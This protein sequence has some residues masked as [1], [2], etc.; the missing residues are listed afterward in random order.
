MIARKLVWALAKLDKKSLL[1]FEEFVASPYFNVNVDLRRF[2]AILLHS[3]LKK[4]KD[5]WASDEDIWQGLYPDTPLDKRRLN[6]LYF[7]LGKLLDD[8]L[9]QREFDEMQ[10][11]QKKVLLDGLL[12]F[13]LFK[14]H[15]E[16]K[17][18]FHNQLIENKDYSSQYAVFQYHLEKSNIKSPFRN[19]I[20]NWLNSYYILEKLQTY[21]SLLSWK[22]MYKLDV[23]IFFMEYIFEKIQTVN[24]IQFP[25]I[26]VYSKITDMLLDEKN[27]GHYFELKFLMQKFIKEL[28]VEMQRDVF[29]TAI[30][31]C[32]TKGNQSNSKFDRESF[33]LFKESVERDIIQEKNEISVPVF[34]NIAFIAVKVGEFLWAEKFIED[35][36]NLVNQKFRDNAVNFSLARL[37][38]NRQNYN[39]VLEYLQLINY[40]DVWYQLGAKIMQAAAYY[41]L[42]EFDAL[43]SFLNAFKMYI[44]R[45]KS[46]TKE[47]KTTHANFIKYTKKLIYLNP[48]EKT[49]VLKLKSEIESNNAV[50]NKVWLLEM[51]DE[52]LNSRVGKSA[53]HY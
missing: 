9:S 2:Y 19:E 48:S 50:V 40:D 38:V 6:L 14:I 26:Q 39:K 1:R 52:Q 28:P 17:K 21:I 27:E 34:R 22:K 44:N 3:L 45:E 47:R 31:Y 51:V 46:L 35:K 16:S 8:Y 10:Y 5:K 49:K 13:K 25:S 41:K 43:E 29:T 36:K 18:E 4:Q 7:N 20:L 33:E 32:I 42:E 23:E 30:S 37:E 12:K 15:Q 24:Y 11:M 53:K